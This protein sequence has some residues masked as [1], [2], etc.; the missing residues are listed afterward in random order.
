MKYYDKNEEMNMICAKIV[1]LKQ[2][3]D[4][5]GC[6][7]AILTRT[8]SSAK[9]ME[10]NL[11]QQI[12]PYELGPSAQRFLD[13]KEVKILFNYL[14]LIGRPGDNFA[15]KEVL[16]TLPGFGEKTVDLVCKEAQLC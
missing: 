5:S 1:R 10:K 6:Q 2:H 8:K 12:I 9:E 14:L 4:G 13:K 11:I 16:G 7:I 15:M 3:F